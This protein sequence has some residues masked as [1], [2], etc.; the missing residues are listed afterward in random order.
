M[1]AGFVDDIS[2]YV[3]LTSSVDTITRVFSTKNDNLV[4]N[5]YNKYSVDVY[6]VLFDG[7]NF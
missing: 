2:G 7:N 3:F 1:Q 4:L 6:Y 5:I